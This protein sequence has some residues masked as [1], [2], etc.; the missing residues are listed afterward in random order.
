M[1]GTA[2][3]LRYPLET[4]P[5]PDQAIEIAEGVLWLRVPMPTVLNHVN[6]YALDDGDKG[7]TIIDSGPH[8]PQT[9]EQ[10]E[11]LMKGPLKG[12]PVWR[13]LITHHH[14]DH[15]GMLGWFME[16]GAEHWT[17]R[18]SYLLSRMLVLDVETEATPQTIAYWKTAGMPPEM[19]AK[20]SKQRP[21]N[22][23]D[24]V[25]P[26]P[27]GFVRL[28]EGETV[29]A[30]GRTWDVRLGGGHA[31][32]HITLWSRDCNLVIGGDQLLPS[33]SP[34][35]GVQAA[36]PF[37]DPLADWLEACER[38]STYAR[39]DQ[40]VLPGHK[41]PYYGLPTRLNQLIVNHHHGLDRL[42]DYIAEPKTVVECFPPLFKRQIVEEIYHLAMIEAYAHLNHLMYEGRATRTL[43]EDG[44]YL[45]Q[46]VPGK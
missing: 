39:E 43:R 44:A 46:A 1:D 42:V 20:R 4:P 34:N 13:V 41:L 15:V 9:V 26:I 21:M 30:G 2:A 6:V 38:L 25:H 5:E 31:P 37:A 45:W 33:I 17:S 11:A 28:Q 40:F 23:A 16:R 10:W 7:W 3:S 27:P 29:E 18:V 8:R 35:V 22:F 12:R 36:E 24:I 19:I 14:P 32:E